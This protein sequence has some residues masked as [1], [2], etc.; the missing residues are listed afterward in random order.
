MATD[1]LTVKVEFDEENAM[2]C[3]KNVLMDEY[4][5]TLDELGELIKAKR[6]G[7]TTIIRTMPAENVREDVQ[8]E[9]IAKKVMI[10]TPA[11]K[12]YFCSV[13]KEE[14]FQTIFC[15]NCGARMMGGGKH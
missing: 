3:I 12:N 9:W 5:I 1:V 7:Q 8:G 11:A 15:P 6:E 14:G 2:N 13:C 10:R 4:G